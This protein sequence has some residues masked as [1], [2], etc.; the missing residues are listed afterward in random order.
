MRVY[1]QVR[2]GGGAG[3]FAQQVW[4]RECHVTMWHCA[5]MRKQLHVY[6]GNCWCHGRVDARLDPMQHTCAAAVLADAAN[7]L[8]PRVCC[9]LPRRSSIATDGCEQRKQRVSRDVDIVSCPSIA[10]RCLLQRVMAVDRS[11]AERVDG[12]VDKV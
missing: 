8:L 6:C 7:C 12:T 4:W 3:W 11:G 5:A 10:L 2:A 1:K 9:A